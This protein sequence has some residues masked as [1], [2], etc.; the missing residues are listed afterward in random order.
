VH[1]LQLRRT[2]SGAVGSSFGRVDSIDLSSYMWRTKGTHGMAH[3][4]DKCIQHNTLQIVGD[5]ASATSRMAG[6][7]PAYSS[8]PPRSCQQRRWLADH[9][10]YVSQ[11]PQPQRQP[12]PCALSCCVRMQSAAGRQPVGRIPL[13][14][15]GLAGQCCATEQP[16]PHSTQYIGWFAGGMN[17]LANGA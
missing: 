11:Q 13:L 8:R 10:Q 4:A 12:P 15:P 6:D 3:V 17:G 7:L 16:A 5:T 14:T 1:L 9:T 2:L